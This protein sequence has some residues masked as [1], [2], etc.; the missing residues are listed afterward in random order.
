MTEECTR[1]YV[2]LVT[3]L[4]I[5]WEMRELLRHV[6]AR[7]RG[8]AV[9]ALLRNAALTVVITRDGGVLLTCHVHSVSV[10][11]TCDAH[12]ALRAILIATGHADVPLRM[13][14]AHVRLHEKRGPRRAHSGAAS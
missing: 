14:H 6:G 2:P 7:L 5:R 4:E 11:G 3:A 8:D 9:P 12:A 1:R 13:E 10:D